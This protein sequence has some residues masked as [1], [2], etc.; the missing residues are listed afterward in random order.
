MRNSEVENGQREKNSSNPDFLEINPDALKMSMNDNTS[1]PIEREEAYTILLLRLDIGDSIPFLFRRIGKVSVFEKYIRNVIGVEANFRVVVT[2]CVSIVEQVQTVVAGVSDVELVTVQPGQVVDISELIN[3]ERQL[4]SQ[5]VRIV[6][7]SPYFPFLMVDDVSNCL[8]IAERNPNRAVVSISESN[9]SDSHYFFLEDGAP[10][11]V[12]ESEGDGRYNGFRQ[13]DRQLY[14]VDRAIRI[15]P[16][17]TDR[18]PQELSLNDESAPIG[19]SLSQTAAIRVESEAD[20]LLAK[21]LYDE[22]KEGHR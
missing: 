13:N 6:E 12:V 3:I 15:W 16:V 18:I 4:E 19:Y 17:H 7:L 20:L 10:L 22:L 2:C 8:R 14:M 1:F 11:R 9:A 21:A 5:G